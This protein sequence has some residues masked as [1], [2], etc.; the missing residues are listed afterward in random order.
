[1]AVT[2][3]DIQ[4]FFKVVGKLAHISATARANAE[5]YRKAAMAAVDQGV[6]G[7]ASEFDLFDFVLAPLKVNVKAAVTALLKLPENVGLLVETYLVT[8]VLPALGVPALSGK[9]AVLDAIRAKMIDFGLQLEPAFA[10]FF[11]DEIG[12]GDLPTAGGTTN[13][14]DAWI[15]DAVV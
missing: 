4:A 5:A 10:A 14:P 11:A 1:M 9:Q 3:N 13:I 8:V 6:S 12:Y 2:S 15:T 7:L